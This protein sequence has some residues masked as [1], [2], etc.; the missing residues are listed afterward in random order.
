MLLDWL[1]KSKRSIIN[2]LFQIAYFQE[3]LNFSDMEYFIQPSTF[4][5]LMNQVEC[6]FLARWSCRQLYASC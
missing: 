2:E 3:V 4:R 5:Q 6:I 1:I